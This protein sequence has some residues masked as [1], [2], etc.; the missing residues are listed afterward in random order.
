MGQFWRLHSIF[1]C[2]QGEER[3]EGETE[4]ERGGG[5][6]FQQSGRFVTRIPGIV[7]TGVR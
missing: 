4:G 7:E 2:R 6:L 3:R 1:V 5:V